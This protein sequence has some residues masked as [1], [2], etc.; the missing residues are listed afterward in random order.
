MLSYHVWQ[1]CS[2]WP[3]I[4]IKDSCR[5]IFFF[6][7]SLQECKFIQTITT[8]QCCALYQKLTLHS[9]PKEHS[10]VWASLVQ[11]SPEAKCFMLSHNVPHHTW[12]PIL[13]VLISEKTK[14]LPVI[15]SSTE[16]WALQQQ[17]KSLIMTFE[18][19]TYTKQQIGNKKIIKH[20]LYCHPIHFS[21]FGSNY[22]RKITPVLWKISSFLSR[23]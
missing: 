1:C 11:T 12:R 9:E 4:A 15:I 23:A 22:Q 16:N 14:K 5:W 20:T 13:L 10:R 3:W 7:S 19:Q 21:T 8:L 6:F 2:S 18:P 17:H